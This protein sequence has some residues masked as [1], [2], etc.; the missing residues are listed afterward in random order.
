M[1]GE[2]LVVVV[3]VFLALLVQ[4][5]RALKGT[6]EE[7]QSDEA[8]ATSIPVTIKRT[9][10]LRES[11]RPTEEPRIVRPAMETFPTVRRRQPRIVAQ[12]WAMR[13]GIVLMAVLGPCRGLERSTPPGE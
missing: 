4:L 12:A 5:V 13:R 8:E 1:T 7:E 3:L 2:Q 6:V 9:A 10:S 11:R